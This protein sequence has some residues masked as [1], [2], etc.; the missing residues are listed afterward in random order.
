VLLPIL[1]YSVPVDSPAVPGLTKPR[2]LRSRVLQASSVVGVL[3]SGSPRGIPIRVVMR[4]DS[5]RSE[6]DGARNTRI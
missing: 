1:E 4:R 3:L 6:C 2:A 5:P